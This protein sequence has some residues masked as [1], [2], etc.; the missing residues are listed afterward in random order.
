MVT[1]SVKKIKKLPSAGFCSSLI[2]L[3]WMSIEDMRCVYGTLVSSRH[4][5]KRTITEVAAQCHMGYKP[6]RC[7]VKVRI[8][9]NVETKAK[10][11]DRASQHMLPGAAH[12]ISC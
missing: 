8:T 4:I 3:A 7:G 10:C 9:G 6:E 11:T 12:T 1:L 5:G 2:K